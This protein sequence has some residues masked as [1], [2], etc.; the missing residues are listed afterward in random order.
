MLDFSAKSGSII[1]KTPIIHPATQNTNPE[2]PG[3]ASKRS[4]KYD[5]HE[6]RDSIRDNDVA[7]TIAA[8]DALPVLTLP[9]PPP[10]PPPLRLP[11]PP[12]LPPE[13][14]EAEVEVLMPNE[15]LRKS[16]DSGD[17]LTF[18][19]QS[20]EAVTASLALPAPAPPLERQESKKSTASTASASSNLE[21]GGS[22]SN[23]SSLK[24]EVKIKRGQDAVDKMEYQNLDFADVTVKSKKHHHHHHHHHKSSRKEE[25]KKHHHHHAK[26][27]LTPEE[28][29]AKEAQERLHTLRYNSGVLENKQ[30]QQPLLPLPLSQPLSA[31]ALMLQTSPELP[32]IDEEV[33]LDEAIRDAI[34]LGSEDADSVVASIQ[35]DSPDSST[36]TAS[37]LLVSQRSC[38]GTDTIHMSEKVIKRDYQDL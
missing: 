17:G 31:Q 20:D 28:K 19:Q 29:L 7:T 38:S 24:K 16:R 25:K 22:S 35:L 15:D 2:D 1:K 37:S 26:K 14:V 30:Q 10:S 18:Q 23:T 5:Y 34:G 36:V 11:T 33:D 6:S 8:A 12:P 9:P 21:S 32:F 4:S 3:S 13:A 27:E